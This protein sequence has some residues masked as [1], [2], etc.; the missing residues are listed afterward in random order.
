MEIR[1]GD[2]GH[3]ADL[4]VYARLTDGKGTVYAARKFEARAAANSAKPG[5]AYAALSTAFDQV[6]ADIVRWS[7]DEGE[8]AAPPSDAGQ[9][10]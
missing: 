2:G 10:K 5:D 8:K 4:S 3:M 7:F 1:A 6:I 9:A